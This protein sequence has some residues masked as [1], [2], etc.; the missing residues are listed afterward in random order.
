MFFF[1]LLVTVGLYSVPMLLEAYG[2]P[3][4]QAHF[5]WALLWALFVV[6]MFFIGMLRRPDKDGHGHT[7]IGFLIGMIVGMAINASVAQSFGGSGF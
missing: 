2:F 5:M 1:S 6:V 4:W 7:P 3:L